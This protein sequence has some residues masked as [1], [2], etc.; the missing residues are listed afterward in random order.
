M[1]HPQFGREATKFIRD[2]GEGHLDVKVLFNPFDPLDVAKDLV[3]RETDEFAFSAAKSSARLENSTNSVV[4]T[5][6]KS[7]SLFILSKGFFYRNS[8]LHIFFYI[9]LDLLCPFRITDS[10]TYRSYDIRVISSDIYHIIFD[11]ILNLF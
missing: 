6:V 8:S 9:P 3:N 5:G 1:E 7:P 10:V 11:F 4:Q 2:H